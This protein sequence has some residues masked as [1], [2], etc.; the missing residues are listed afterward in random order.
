MTRRLRGL[1]FVFATLV[2]C[3]GWAPSSAW[4]EDFATI[5]RIATPDTR[6]RWHAVD[7][8][9]AAAKVTDEARSPLEVG[10]V[11]V[12][13][14]RL[15]TEE[16]RVTIRLGQREHITMSPGSTL[17]LEERSVLQQLGEVYYQVRDVFS[18][19]YGTVQTAVEGTE[20][21]IAGQDSG[22]AVRV[23]EGA[24]QVSNA[25]EAVR[26]R[27]GQEV[28]VATAAPPPMPTAMTM[29]ATRS[30]RSTAWTLGRPRLQ[31]GLLAGGGLLG[32]DAGAQMQT[33]AAVRVLPFLNVVADATQGYSP[34]SHRSGSGVGLEFALGGLSIGGTG[35]ATLER[36]RYPCGGRYAAVHVGGAFHGRYTMDIT[37]RIFVAA[38]ARG[39]GNADGLEAT[40]SLGGGVSL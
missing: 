36:W 20:F 1:R 34:T 14:D 29:A 7:S 19:Q 25:G 5:T 24:V 37:R 30:A 4:A 35:T 12:I 40:F 6:G 38:Q 21:A 16:A 2:I 26:V 32:S 3:L 18:V 15:Q 39:V 31:L 8:T 27:R 22:V 9:P 17:V 28:V 10:M 33:F 11:L 23:T 13:G